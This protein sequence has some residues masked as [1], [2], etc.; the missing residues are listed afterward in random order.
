MRASP[1]TAP[2]PQ[3]SPAPVRL[4]KW[5][6]AARLFKTRALAAQAIEAGH[7]LVD[8]RDAKPSRAVRPGDRI[9]LRQPGWKRIVMVLALSALRGPANQARALY[10]DTPESLQAREAAVQARRMGVEPALHIEQ[11]R[12][13]KKDRRDL[14]RWQRWSAS[15]DDG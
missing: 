6:W 15:L 3:A 10:E 13:T 14:G 7:V 2:T 4:D 8:D 12:P 9:T 5:L 1:R 11:G